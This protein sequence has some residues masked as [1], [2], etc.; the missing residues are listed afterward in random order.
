MVSVKQ[1]QKLEEKIFRTVELIKALKEEN[2]ILKA[3]NISANKRVEEL[4]QIISD[5]RSTQIE[6]EEGIVNAIKQLDE[7]DKISENSPAASVSNKPNTA[8]EHGPAGKSSFIQNNSASLSK[9]EDHPDEEV[10]EISID[11]SKVSQNK[12]APG[13]TEKSNTNQLDIF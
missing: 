11:Y 3:E 9:K 1:V 13:T 10:E 7:L 8:I 6:I 5:Y 4:E 12:P 2:K